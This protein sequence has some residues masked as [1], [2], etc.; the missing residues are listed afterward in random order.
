M[1]EFNRLEPVRP[2]VFH[3]D[4]ELTLKCNLDCGYCGSHDNSRKHPSLQECLETVDFLLEYADINFI[5]S[6][7]SENKATLNIFG[8][9]AIYHPNITEIF[10]YIRTQHSLLYKDRYSLS[11]CLITN[12]IASEKTWAKIVES[13]DY[14]TVSYHTENNDKQEEQFRNN[15]LHLHNSGKSYHI[16]VLMNPLLF[17]KNLSFIDFCRENKINYLPRQLDHWGWQTRK[18]NYTDDQVKW[19]EGTYKRKSTKPLPMIRVENVTKPKIKLIDKIKHGFRKVM[20]IRTDM[21]KIGR[22]CCGGE[23]LCVDGKF[24]ENVFF[25]PDNRFKGWHCSVNR[26]FVFVKQDDQSIRHNKDCRQNFDGSVGPLGYLKDRRKILDTMRHE[27]TTGIRPDIIC[28]KKMC[29]CGLCAP[30]AKDKTTYDLMM[31]RYFK[32]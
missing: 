30:K 17:Q 9:E 14:F 27:I 10:D 22:A 5:D 29:F 32:S 23:T 3:I 7:M 4:W 2:Q 11:L 31:T 28:N 8:G 6:V 16:A 13:I 18:Y 1:P 26:F 19:L 24:D 25:V 12:A 21:T 20:S 15:V